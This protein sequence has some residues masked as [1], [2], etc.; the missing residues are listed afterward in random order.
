M[1]KS[2]RIKCDIHRNPLKII[3]SGFHALRFI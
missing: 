1:I 3:N 2:Q